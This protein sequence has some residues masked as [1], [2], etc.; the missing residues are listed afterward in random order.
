MFKI[1]I[2]FYTCHFF[3]WRP[4]LPFLAQKISKRKLIT[5]L[6][7]PDGKLE[8]H[9]TYSKVVFRAP[10]PCTDPRDAAAPMSLSDSWA[11]WLLEAG[12]LAWRPLLTP[13]GAIWMGRGPG[14]ERLLT[15][16]GAPCASQGLTF[17][18]LTKMGG[19]GQK[20]WNELT[21]LT[22]SSSGRPVAVLVKICDDGHAD[23][24]IV[25]TARPCADCS[26]NMFSPSGHKNPT[27]G[28]I[29]CFSREEVETREVNFV[30]KVTQLVRKWAG[31]GAGLLD[32]RA[33]ALHWSTCAAGW[34]KKVGHD[35]VQGLMKKLGSQSDV[36][37]VCVT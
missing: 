8:M 23:G 14:M 27:V 31:I 32:P 15:R 25:T 20:S 17:P 37:S 1:L 26:M 28:T 30:F 10:E 24:V 21:L 3:V 22:P 29:I 11:S 33:H 16:L 5:R 18:L 13:L 2:C 34:Q 9:L 12:P 7:S 35:S 6:L 36:R 19:L 4:F